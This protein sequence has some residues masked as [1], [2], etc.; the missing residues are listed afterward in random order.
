MG[1]VFPIV[2]KRLG[3]TISQRDL[4]RPAKR[5]VNLAEVTVIIAD[6]DDVP[7]GR[8]WDQLVMSAVI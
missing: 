7:V 4:R 1:A 3:Q 8:E 6:V 2:F 5:I